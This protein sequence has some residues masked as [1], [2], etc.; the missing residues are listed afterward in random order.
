MAA[1][2]FRI[3]SMSDDEVLNSKTLV[4]LAVLGFL[5]SGPQPAAALITRIKRAGGKTFT[6]TADFIEDRLLCLIAQGLVDG[7]SSNDELSATPGGRGHILRLLRLELDPNAATLRAVCSTLK[8]CMLQ[9][10]DEETRGDLIEA[11]CR[12]RDCCPTSSSARDLPTCPL[13]ERCLAIEE[14]RQVQENRFWQEQLL[15]EG[16]LDPVH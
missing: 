6:P 10:V 8:L 12:S 4:D 3:E 16:L 7:P 14:K 1:I 2:G 13:M 15:E 11:L 5:S 9:L